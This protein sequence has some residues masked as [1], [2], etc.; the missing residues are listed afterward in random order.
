MSRQ[1]GE[2][3]GGRFR[4]LAPLG[5]GGMGEVYRAEQV[6]LGRQVALKIL[7]PHVAALPNAIDRLQREAQ[8][9]ARLRHPASVE[10][11]DFG[12]AGGTIYIAMELLH[13]TPLD[14][15][16]TGAPMAPA[17]AVGLTQQVLEVLEA[18]HALGI[19]HRDLKPANLFLELGERIKVVDFGLALVEEGPTGARLTQQGQTCGTP[20]YMAPEQCLGHLVDGRAD[21]YALGC[22]LYEM[23]TGGPPF[24]T[25]GGMT[26]MMAQL[27]QEPKPL[28]RKGAFVPAALQAVVLRS[29]AKLADERFPTARAMS[30]ALIE[31]NELSGQGPR[32]E[33]KKRSRGGSDELVFASKRVVSDR[34]VGFFSAPTEGSGVEEALAAAGLGIVRATEGSDLGGLGAVIVDAQEGGLVLAA[35]VAAQ[36]GAPPVLLCGPESDLDLM[37][38]AIQSGIFDYLPLPLDPTDLAKK[39]AR[40]LRSRR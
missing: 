12:T 36:P 35:S 22:T 28:G 40:A 31:A 21:L 3:V 29:L 16:L 6:G 11:F 19:V 27:Y 38:Q 23:L 25:G 7:H 9:L 30:E 14:G 34:P 8:I 20:A 13:G 37:T 33:G 2:V 32:G 18:A 26:V 10:I 17:R 1:A 15:I 24:G 4:I 39:V 5:S